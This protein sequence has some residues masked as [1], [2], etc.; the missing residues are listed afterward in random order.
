VYPVHGRHKQ[1]FPLNFSRDNS[2]EGKSVLDSGA[3]ICDFFRQE[4]AP[5]K[6]IISWH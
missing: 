2:E 4:N 3:E 1:G 6:L 5:D